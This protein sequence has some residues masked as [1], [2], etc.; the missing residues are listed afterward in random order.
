MG[1]FGTL[2]ATPTAAVSE[3]GRSVNSFGAARIF[4]LPFPGAEI[5]QTDELAHS[6]GEAGG[7]L[8]DVAHVFLVIRAPQGCVV[9]VEEFDSGLGAIRHLL[10]V[11]RRVVNG[12]ALGECGGPAETL[13]FKEL[14]AHVVDGRFE[15]DPLIRLALPAAVFSVAETREIRCARQWL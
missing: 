15:V 5:F 2:T 4:D 14:A 7:L 6:G 11:V 3:C 9:V 12:I 10:E 13:E 8:S 1:E